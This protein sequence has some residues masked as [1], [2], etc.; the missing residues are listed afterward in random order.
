MTTTYR[1]MNAKLESL[2]PFVGNSVT[3]FMENGLYVIRSYWTDIA[4]V[5]PKTKK[6]VYFDQKRYSNTTSKIQ[7]RIRLVY[8]VE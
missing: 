5:D 1:E 4:K 2:T 7:H 8:G 3:A 6:V